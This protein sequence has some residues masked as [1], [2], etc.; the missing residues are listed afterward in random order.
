MRQIQNCIYT[1]YLGVEGRCGMARSFGLGALYVGGCYGNEHALV[2]LGVAAVGVAT[3]YP[4]AQTTAC[5][6]SA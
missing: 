3:A 6:E 1:R 4:R 2:E 5:A